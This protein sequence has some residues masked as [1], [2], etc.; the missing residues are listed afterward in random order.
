MTAE[1][2]DYAV[3]PESEDGKHVPQVPAANDRDM[4]AGYFTVE[5][6]RCYQTTGYPMPDPADIDWS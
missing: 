3:C 1:H 6:A 2:T 5:C 4:P